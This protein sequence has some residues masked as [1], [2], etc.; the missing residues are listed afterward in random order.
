MKL[1]YI[2]LADS[3]SDH[4]E[5]FVT[6]F[7]K[8][9]AYATILTVVDGQ[10]LLSYLAGCPWKDMPS[11]IVLNYRQQDMTAPDVI[12]ELLIDTRYLTIPKIVTTSTEDEN[13]IEE[14]RMLG[15]KNFLKEPAGLFDLE[16]NVRK[17]DNLLKTEFGLL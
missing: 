5:S 13:E 16:T 11:L 6:V 14:C 7:E 15:I 3:D 17:I 4:R 10:S 1:P 12:R 8:Q 9:V 2:L